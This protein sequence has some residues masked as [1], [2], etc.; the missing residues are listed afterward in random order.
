MMINDILSQAGAR[1]RRKRVGR[2]ES[3][4]LGRTCG[5]GNKGAQSRAGWGGRETQEGGQI[6]LYRRMPKRGFSNVNFRTAYEVVNLSDLEAAFSDGE[7]VNPAALQ[8]LRLVQGGGAPVKILGDGRLSKKLTVEAHAFSAR[9]REAIEKAGGAV[10][11]IERI[12]SA[13][14][15]KSKRNSAKKRKREPG[16]GRLAKKKSARIQ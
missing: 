5:R 10:Q 1:K 16:V 15:A 13:A 4:G 8:K 6:P 14:R 3:S 2:G 9:A 12:D 7:R 11:Q